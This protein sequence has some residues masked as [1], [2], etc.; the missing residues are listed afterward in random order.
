MTTLTGIICVLHDSHKLDDV[1]SKLL[2]TRKGIFGEF[3][4]GSNAGLRGGDPNMSFVD[5][6]AFDWRRSRVFEGILLGFGRVPKTRVIHGRHAQI[7]SDAPDPSRNTFNAFT[8]RKNHRKLT[9]FQLRSRK[10]AP[11]PYI[12]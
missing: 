6:G 9:A 11:E 5:F 1:V 8:R 3:L 2:D 10:V 12:L 7:L 4:V